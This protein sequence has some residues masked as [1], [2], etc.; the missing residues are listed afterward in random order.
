VLALSGTL[1]YLAGTTSLL[2]LMVFF[3]VH[4]SLIVIK[5]RTDRSMRTFCA[6]TVVPFL[7]A[8]S[9]I[10]LMPFVPRDSLLTAALILA[11][12]GAIAIAGLRKARS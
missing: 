10:A 2:L 9:C 3:T 1:S 7:G 6:P 5:R 12:G 11:L 4:V 8:L